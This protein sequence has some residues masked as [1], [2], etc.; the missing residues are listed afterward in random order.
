MENSASGSWDMLSPWVSYC[1]SAMPIT[2]GEM[3]EMMFRGLTGSRC[4][5]RAPQG[6]DDAPCPSRLQPSIRET[7]RRKETWEC[8]RRQEN[9]KRK[10]GV[11]RGQPQHLGLR[12]VSVASSVHSSGT[13][14]LDVNGR[15]FQRE[16]A[17]VPGCHCRRRAI[18]A[19]WML[20]AARNSFAEKARSNNDGNINSMARDGRE[21]VVVRCHALA[22]R[23]LV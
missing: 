1:M 2:I 3:G 5:W 15:A 23:S 7:P 13:M 18:S 16:R 6:G 20:P 14:S 10:G 11:A 19:E 8:W 17:S 12:S 21:M 22:C 4:R 9:G